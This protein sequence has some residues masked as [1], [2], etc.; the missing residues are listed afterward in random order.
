MQLAQQIFTFDH[1]AD[2]GHGHVVQ[3]LAW[4]LQVVLDLAQAEGVIGRFVPV[5]L[6]VDG[7]ELEPQALGLRFPVRTWGDRQA[8][9]PQPP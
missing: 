1:F 8:L 6:T 4:P 9:H 5:G 2:Q 7:V 3:F